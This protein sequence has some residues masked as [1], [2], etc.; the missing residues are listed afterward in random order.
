MKKILVYISF[1]IAC[2]LSPANNSA[3]KSGS[4]VVVEI[5]K[6]E[7]KDYYL[8]IKL[9]LRNVSSQP[10]KLWSPGCLAGKF[11]VTF[12]ILDPGGARVPIVRR[13]VRDTARISLSMETI[14]PGEGIVVDYDLM[15]GSWST[16]EAFIG[17]GNAHAIQ[18]EL[19][20]PASAERWRGWSG[21]SVSKKCELD[22]PI[23]R[24]LPDEAIIFRDESL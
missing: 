21:R 12:Y 14:K 10:I 4:D 9:R 13:R 5:E 17:A 11:C 24:I 3:A 8:K 20:V 7:C 16:S 6:I 2:H 15:D 18:A 23:F 1:L 19:N 22:Q